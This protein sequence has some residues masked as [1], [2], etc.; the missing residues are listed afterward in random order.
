MYTHT[1]HRAEGQALLVVLMIATLLTTLV[2][3]AAFQTVNQTRTTQN[4]ADS[5][6]AQQAAQGVLEQIL[7]NESTS[8][9]LGTGLNTAVDLVQ[10]VVTSPNTFVTENTVTKDSQYM[11][12]TAV[13]YDSTTNTLGAAFFSGADALEIYYADSGTC[14]V[15]E[16]THIG[17][18]NT[19]LK[20]TISG[21]CDLNTAGNSTAATSVNTSIQSVVFTRRLSIPVGTELTT[22]Q[23][24][25]I[26]PLFA[27][28]KLGFKRSDIN[29]QLPPQGQTITVV[30]Q[31]QGGAQQEQQV[32]R[33]YP[34]IAEI[35]FFTT[36][37]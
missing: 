9:S 26:R 1:P 4:Q 23:M 31:T 35:P 28:T 25:V 27:G 17:A 3:T 32:Y 6:T 5:Q 11:F 19:I 12:Y 24:L 37:F 18:S 7:N 29:L 34:Q 22:T 15:L 20:R 30:V 14:P 8:N 33:A 13:D 10:Q 2:G 16:I 36:V 21:T